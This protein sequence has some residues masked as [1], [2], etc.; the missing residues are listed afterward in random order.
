MMAIQNNAYY[1]LSENLTAGWYEDQRMGLVNAIDN[2]IARRRCFRQQRSRRFLRIAVVGCGPSLDDSIAYLRQHAEDFVI[3]ACGSSI[4]PLLKNGIVPDYHVHQERTED[5]NTV[6]NWV[7]REA[8][9]DIVAIKLNV[10]GTVVDGFY[11]DA[12]MFQK[13]NDP[14][15]ALLPETFP[16]VQHISPTVTNTAIALSGLLE[17]DEVYLFGCDYGAT[18]D[19]KSMHAKHYA[20]EH[21]PSKRFDRQSKYRLP[22][23]FD[24]E[25]ISTGLLVQSQGES[26]VAI[27][28]NQGTRW[29]N[30]GDGARIAGATETRVD[31]L[32]GRFNQALDKTRLKQ[33][34]GDCFVDDYSIEEIAATL[35]DIGGSMIPEYFAAIRDSLPGP[36]TTRSAI[37]ESLILLYRIADVGQGEN[38]FVPHKLYSGAIKRFVENVYI[39]INLVTS[40]AQA[41]TFYAATVDIFDAYL[42]ELESDAVA[43]INDSLQKFDEQT[44]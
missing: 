5:E 41:A 18:A 4:T 35:S 34:I 16:V 26:E 42:T 31:A 40:D 6:V 3:L 36:A 32:P 19:R 12:W 29:H 20:W 23:N 21:L 10:I 8:C 11:Q 39:Q 7:G 15:S 1:V 25:V 27:A 17:A 9:R 28:D 22:G 37:L 14:G 2:L 13:Y 30:V 44:P 24:R 33:E 38:R 43:L